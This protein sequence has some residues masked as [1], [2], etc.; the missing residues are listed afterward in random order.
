[1]ATHEGSTSPSESECGVKVVHKLYNGT[2]VQLGGSKRFLL[3]KA[4]SL[5]GIEGVLWAPIGVAHSLHDAN[6][7]VQQSERFTLPNGT[8]TKQVRYRAMPTLVYQSEPSPLFEKNAHAALTAACRAASKELAPYP[9]LPSIDEFAKRFGLKRA[10]KKAAFSI[11][12]LTG[13]TGQQ[14]Y[15][16]I[17]ETDDIAIADRLHGCSEMV[18][19]PNGDKVPTVRIRVLPFLENNPELEG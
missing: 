8:Q 12:V 15:M 9:G 3:E 1:M 10:A 11:E 6:T 16:A 13:E 5:P 18:T 2:A 19:L 7:I 4:E 17:G 14:Q